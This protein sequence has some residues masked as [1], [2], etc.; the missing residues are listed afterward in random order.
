VAAPG[1]V[2]LHVRDQGLGFPA[3]FIPH[4]FE[5]F[6]R[7]D[8]SRTG[9]GDGLGLSIAQAIA[10]AHGGSASAGNRDGGGADVWLT[11]PHQP[12]QPR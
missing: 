10:V 4:A 6:S 3:D 12:S 11:L 1:I 2:E 8:S 5:R 9:H 7:P